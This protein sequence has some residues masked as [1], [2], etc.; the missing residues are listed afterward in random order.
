MTLVKIC[1]ITNWQDAK[2]A[3][4]AGADMLGFVCDANSERAIDVN[5]LCEIAPR[6]PPKIVRVGVFDRAPSPVWG[7]RPDALR[8]F[9]QIQFYD[10]RVW[11]DVIREN[12][13]MRRKIRAFHVTREADLRTIAHCNDLAFSYLVNVNTGPVRGMN[14][15]TY[16]WEI[17][18][19]VHQFGRRILLAGGLTADNVAA[20]I[21][22]VRPYAVD[23]SVA[24]EAAPGLKDALKMNAFVEA[25][26]GKA[27]RP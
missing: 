22:R 14:P 24:V 10:N 23:V 21:A 25:V 13:D 20:A 1:G 9:H 27:R 16:G 11:T 8:L 6:L 12:W 3:V 26:R 5:V 2:N 7:T 19:E 17:A 18:A 4:D 15:E